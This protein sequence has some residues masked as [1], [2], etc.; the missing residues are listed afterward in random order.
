MRALFLTLTAGSL[1]FFGVSCESLKTGAS[2]PVPFTDP[3]TS[4]G[5]NIEAK[6]LPPKF[7]IGLD[8][9]GAE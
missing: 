9:K 8:V 3:A 4:V 7:C 6:V 2:L 5:V 1:L